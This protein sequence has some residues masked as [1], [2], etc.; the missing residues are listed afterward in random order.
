VGA[1]GPTVTSAGL[2]LAGTFAVLAISGGNGPGSSQIEA[3]GFGLAVGILLDTFVVRTVLVPSTVALLGR[4][5]WW[6]SAMGRRHPDEPPRSP[7]PRQGRGR[8]ESDRRC[9]GRKQTMTEALAQ[10]AAGP[11]DLTKRRIYI[12]MSALL[13][14]MFLAA[15]DQTVVSTALPTI[16]GDLG[17]ASHLSWVVHRLPVGL[18]GVHAPVGQARRPLR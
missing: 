1:T 3:I 7:L 17:G 2:V 13:L 16:V 18:D 15:L 8:E 4:W 14:G 11:L 6:P 10:P 12:I 9:G 5:N